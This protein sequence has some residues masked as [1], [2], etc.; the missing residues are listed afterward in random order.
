[1]T[2]PKL[3]W[4]WKTTVTNSCGRAMASSWYGISWGAL[5]WGALRWDKNDER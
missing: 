1:M 3:R 5:F 4:G 2:W